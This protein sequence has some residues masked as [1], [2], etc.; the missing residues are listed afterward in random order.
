MSDK[1]NDPADTA[2]EIHLVRF[3][4]SRDEA[5]GFDSDFRPIVVPADED[6]PA[7]PPK[8]PAAPEP[9]EDPVQDETPTVTEPAKKVITM[10]GVGAGKPTS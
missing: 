3:Y 1:D 10:P 9:A 5:M 7:A 8:A 4:D 2:Q 6:Y